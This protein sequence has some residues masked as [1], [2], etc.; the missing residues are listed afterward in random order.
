MTFDE[1][2]EGD[3]VDVKAQVSGTHIRVK[4]LTRLYVSEYE[5]TGIIDDFNADGWIT[6]DGLM[7]SLADDAQYEPDDLFEQIHSGI[8]VV[9]LNDQD[10]DGQVDTVTIQ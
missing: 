8:S 5:V 9:K 4:T 2:V 6:I 1:L 3:E 7:F 10:K